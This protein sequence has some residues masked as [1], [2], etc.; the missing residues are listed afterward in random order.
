MLSDFVY[1]FIFWLV[2]FSI[3]LVFLPL[4]VTI[5]NKFFDRGYIFSKI[6]G[7]TII[8]Y[9][10]WI[11]SSF[12]IFPF[13]T[14]E[15]ILVFLAFIIFNTY[16]ASKT[17]LKQIITLPIKLF[18]V[19]EA[20]FLFCLTFWSYIRGF[21][22]Q[23]H[24][25]EKFMDY[26]FVN[27]IIRSTYFPPKDLWLT[28]FTIN[29]YYFGHLVTVVL[30]KLSGINPDIT[31]NLMIATLFAF[32][33]SASFSIG[34]NLFHKLNPNS[35]KLIFLAGFLSAY[36]VSLG[37]NLHT[38]YIFFQTYTPPDKPVPFWQLPLQLNLTG[39]WYPNATR[40]IPFTIHEFPIYSFVVSDLHGHVLDI[41]FVLVFIAFI[42]K[43]FFE[44][45]F[46][47][48]DLLLSSLLVAVFLMTNVLDGPIYLMIIG[49]V[50]YSK[51]VY[52]QAIDKDISF[53]KSMTLNHN[54]VILNVIKQVGII[55]VLSIVLSFPF[56]V[57]FK[58]FG[59]GI[60]VIC[61]PTFLTKIGHIGPLLFEPDHCQR[62][63]LWM[64]LIL[65]GLPLFLTLVY[66]YYLIYKKPKQ[67]SKLHIL[68][69]T[70]LISGFILVAIPEIF[71]VKDIYPAYYRANT[72][73]KFGY[74][75]FIIFGLIG[76][77]ILTRIFA[78]AKSIP[79]VIK[80]VTCFLLFLA[81]I[82]PYFA[83][84]SYYGSLA[85]YK[86][87]NGFNYFSTLYPQDYKAILWLR[88]NISGQPVI[89]EAQGDSYTDYAR[90]SSNTGLPTILG[91]PVHEW[92]WRGRYSDNSVVTGNFD[93]TIHDVPAP[94]VNEVT[95]LYQ[96]SDIQ[97][98]KEL[99]KK[100]QVRYVFIGALERQKY[101]NLNE[102][103]FTKLG[104][105][106][107]SDGFTSIYKI[108]QNL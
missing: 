1:I 3:G 94:R 51:K 6:L 7:L 12:K 55:T 38:I 31:Y 13:A 40:F 26:G 105:I 65:W 54:S 83:I 39:Y 71:Y 33:F 24:G 58:P 73:F 36:L 77:Y 25:L 68:V 100:Y 19:E 80:V 29:Y 99:L 9:L 52:Q 86:G 93:P 97:L 32:A 20:I 62:S 75:A 66:L 15:I 90:V 56:W 11:L 28:P 82:Y 67:N 101:L 45:K 79:I 63:P 103:K 18:V 53:I 48:L 98:T 81:A 59:A 50:F 23:I 5:F 106:V 85:S 87:L 17:G 60:G 102:V 35:N 10:I 2:L 42:I 46:T 16:L 22:P 95:T 108:N 107:F 61:A 43:F 37:G 72:V 74:Q 34:T 78:S 14:W 4:T 91:W 76:G 104:K 96:T 57:N 88:Q 47:K 21:N 69:T 41:P 92:L 70:L 84:N 49:L 44:P 30:T 89:L 27:S 64:L 8:S